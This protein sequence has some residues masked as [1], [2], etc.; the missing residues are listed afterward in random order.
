MINCVVAVERHQGIGF[1]GSMPWPR[2]S[3]DMRWFR[4]LTEGHIVLMGSVTYRGL[5]R[6]LSN[7]EN[8][9]ITRDDI[10]D[11][12]C[13]RSPVEALA[14]CQG[15]W[16]DREIFII[17]GQTLYDC[18][19]SIAERFYV[20]EIDNDYACDRFFNLD[21][22]RRNFQRVIEHGSFTDPVPYTIREYSKC[23]ILNKHT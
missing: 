11:V 2:L 4:T 7:R 22:V 10:S 19:M 23:P 12:I 17:G 3:D 14:Q 21:Y 6:P 13:C 5:G 15:R 16:P 9:V 18:T 20:T 1:Q 8:I